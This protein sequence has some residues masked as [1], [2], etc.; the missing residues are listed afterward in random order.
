MARKARG[1]PIH[2][3]LVLDKPQGM[4][5]SRA[6][7]AV[8]RIL[9]AAKA[10]HGGT[11]DP[12]ATGVLPIALGEA[13]KTVPWV[14]AGRKLYRFALR[15]GEARDSDDALGRVTAQSPVRP[16]RAAVE[17][18]LPRFVGMIQQRPPAFSA[19][20]VA[21]ERAYDLARAGEVV[22]LAPRPVDIL[23]LRLLS[24]PDAD[25]A[26]FEAMVGK[27]TYIRALARDLGEALG[28]HAHV[29]QLRRLA[30]GRFGLERA[31]SLDNLAALGHSAAASVHLLPL[32]TALDD[33]PALALTEAEAHR[34]RR[35]QAVT[36]LRPS[37][38][39]RID[40][41]GDGATVCAT[42]GGKLVAV[43]EIAAGGLRPVRVMNL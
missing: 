29:T 11:L 41:L 9:D 28:T 20:K 21:G 6:V 40:Q 8:R 2:G 39:A 42:T 32:E 23:A 18:A 27:G 31:I 17:A 10:G 35:G 13:T 26:E 3:W 36:P 4:T 24:T 19:L 7:A 33:I 1:L 25:H 12:L 16:D 37:D 30:V 43:T 38:R 14:M 22:A 34:L 15:W 5:S